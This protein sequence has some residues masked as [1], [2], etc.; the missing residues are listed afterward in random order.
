MSKRADLNSL[1]KVWETQELK[2]Y[3]ANAYAKSILEKVAVTVAPL[4]KRRLWKV[5][6]EFLSTTCSF[7]FSTQRYHV[8]LGKSTEGILS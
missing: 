2:T 7:C 6:S 1:N 5:R 3:D 8:S 4:M